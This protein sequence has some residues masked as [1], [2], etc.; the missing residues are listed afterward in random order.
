MVDSTAACVRG[1]SGSSRSRTQGDA[2]TGRYWRA[3]GR[4][5][6]ADTG[7]NPCARGRG[8][9]HLGSVAGADDPRL[10]GEH[11]RLDAVAQAELAQDPGDVALDRRLAEEELPRDLRVGHAARDEAQDLELARA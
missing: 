6:G 11:H 5:S 8:I 2:N 10:V 1:R 3:R 7:R 9:N 4:R